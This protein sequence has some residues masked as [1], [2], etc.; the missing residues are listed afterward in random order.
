MTVWDMKEVK[1]IIEQ[2]IE[3][4]DQAGHKNT[5]QFIELVKIEEELAEKIADWMQGVDGC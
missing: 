3:K 2:A 5:I 1:E 4:M